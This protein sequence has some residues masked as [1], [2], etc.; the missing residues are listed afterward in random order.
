[1]GAPSF[2]Q[3]STPSGYVQFIWPSDITPADLDD[4]M[5]AIAIQVRAIRRVA[6]ARGIDSGEAGETPKAARPEGQEPGGDSHAPN[7]GEAS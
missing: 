5:E 7:Q 6:E 3:W 1:M 4:A 2:M